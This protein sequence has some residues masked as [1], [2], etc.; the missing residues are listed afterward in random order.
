MF[1]KKARRD[2]ENTNVRGDGLRHLL[3]LFL[4]PGL[5]L[6]IFLLPQPEGMSDE[7]RVVL[8][9]IARIAAWWVFEALLIPVSSLL[10]IVLLPLT[11]VVPISAAS[12]PYAPPTAFLILSSFIIAYCMKRWKLHCRISLKIIKLMEK[13]PQRMV[14]GP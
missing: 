5:F 7:A 13:S 6:V 14:L 9:C 3:G 11:G 4:G 8:A 2:D 10:L 12:A 1:K